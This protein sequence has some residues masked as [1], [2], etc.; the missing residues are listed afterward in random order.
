MVQS[1]IRYKEK[2]WVMSI[3]QIAYSRFDDAEPKHGD[4]DVMHIIVH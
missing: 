1:L 3:F 4:C 2:V